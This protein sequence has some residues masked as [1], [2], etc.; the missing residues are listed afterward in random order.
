MNKD[1]VKAPKTLDEVAELF[2]ANKKQTDTYH[3]D[4]ETNE[5]Q[6]VFVNRKSRRLIAKN[7]LYCP[8]CGKILSS[9][10][11]KVAVRAEAKCFDCV[12]KEESQW[13]RIGLWEPIIKYKMLKTKIDTLVDELDK[14]NDL[15][16]GQESG[17]IKYV[18]NEEGMMERWN[19]NSDI[20]CDEVK[21]YTEKVQTKL[22]ELQ[23]RFIK[24]E[25]DLNTN[26][27]NW[28]ELLTGLEEEIKGAQ[29]NECA[30]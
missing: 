23:E 26:I 13:K 25:E 12:I 6:R 14:C 18:T 30:N 15:I 3:M 28:K 21:E 27:P 2:A 20:L 16:S 11:D 5:D 4:V 17:S 8:A 19:V 24:Q 29:E 1:K 10:Q 9:Q 22:N 7:S